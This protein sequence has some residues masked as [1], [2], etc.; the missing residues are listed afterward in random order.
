M[1]MLQCWCCVGVAVLVLSW[2][3]SAGV[4]A[5]VGVVVL[6]LQCWCCS[7]GVAVLVL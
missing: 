3:C 7:V 1:N 5:S 4:A 6:V 2:C